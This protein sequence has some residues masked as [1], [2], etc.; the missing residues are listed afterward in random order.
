MD[1]RCSILF[2]T[3]TEPE[4]TSTQRISFNEAKW[5]AMFPD[6]EFQH[7][8]LFHGEEK[9]DP[10][11]PTGV[12]FREKNTTGIIL[13][14]D[15]PKETDGTIDGYDVIYT[16]GQGLFK[17]TTDDANMVTVP[18]IPGITAI[19]ACVAAITNKAVK[20]EML[21]VSI[22]VFL[23]I[24]DASTA[25]HYVPGAEVSKDPKNNALVDTFAVSKEGKTDGE[26][27]DVPSAKPSTLVIALIG[28]GIELALLSVIGVTIYLYVP[29][30]KPSTLVIALIGA[31]IVLALLS[32]IGVTI[33]LCM[34]NKGRYEVS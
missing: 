1:F 6:H 31:G 8:N 18:L 17:M 22:P 10:T 23:D 13:K 9:E 32:V 20:S 7:L 33:C 25:V 2:Y 30:A 5:N 24:S 12:E 11:V 26:F 3:V 21:N 29:S 4:A 28:V 16:Y 15:S 14:W 34:R 19:E 27:Q